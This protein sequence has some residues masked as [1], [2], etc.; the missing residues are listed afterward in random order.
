MSTVLTVFAGFL[1]AIIAVLGDPAMVPGN[2][3][4][5]AELRHPKLEAT[6]I[7]YVWLFYIYLIAIAMMFTAVLLHKEPES[8]VSCGV[9]SAIEFLYLFFAVFSFLL[10][11]GLPPTIGKIQLARSNAEV[12]ARRRAAGI[13]PPE[14]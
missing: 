2:S 12:E 5:D 1:V 14:S 6:I 7:R 13:K 4:R 9:K 3:W 8:V 11:L 10:T